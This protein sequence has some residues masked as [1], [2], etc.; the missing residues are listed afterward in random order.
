[1]KRAEENRSS[2]LDSGY[3]ST[4]LFSSSDMCCDN[5]SASQDNDHDVCSQGELASCNT[6]TDT[7]ISSDMSEAQPGVKDLTRDTVGGNS[8]RFFDNPTK[9]SQ[10]EQSKQRKSQTVKSDSKPAGP[11]AG[12][13]NF[14]GQHEN[15]DSKKADKYT[16]A[17]FYHSIIGKDA[18]LNQGWI[19]IIS[20][21]GNDREN[22]R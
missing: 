18:H 7:G 10:P 12:V 8:L 1:M 2:L 5:N 16:A 13:F 15:T 20:P 9:S 11:F 4:P 6:K 17:C 14:A 19:R 3:T 22:H 21:S